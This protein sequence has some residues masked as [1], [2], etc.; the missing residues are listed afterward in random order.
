[1]SYVKNVA[2]D[3]KCTMKLNMFNT[4]DGKIISKFNQIV[5]L[6]KENVLAG[7]RVSVRNSKG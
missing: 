7:T 6:I 2:I 4:V 5:Y 1:M 3:Q